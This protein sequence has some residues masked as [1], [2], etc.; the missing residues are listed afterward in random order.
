MGE[1]EGEGEGEGS[2]APTFDPFELLAVDSDMAPG[3]VTARARF[4]L[5]ADG[6]VRC[7][8]EPT[9]DSDQTQTP[10]PV[11]TAVNSFTLISELQAVAEA[12][13][14]YAKTYTT[15]EEIDDAKHLWRLLPGVS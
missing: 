1:G 10:D 9:P 2:D 4:R 6:S 11:Q 12:I 14:I 8:V 3:P 15:V 7:A 5:G 13:V